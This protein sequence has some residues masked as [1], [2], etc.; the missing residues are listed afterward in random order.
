[1]NSSPT[2][3]Q[4]A[5]DIALREATALNMIDMVGVGP[6]ITMPLIVQAMGRTAGHHPG[7]L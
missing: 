6:F 7:S 3:P 5:R 4:L 2:R 1:M